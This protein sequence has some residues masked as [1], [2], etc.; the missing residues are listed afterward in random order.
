VTRTAAAAALAEPELRAL[1]QPT[2]EPAGGSTL[3]LQGVGDGAAPEPSSASRVFAI[4]P[5][6]LVRSG[7]A[8][9]ARRAFGCHAHG[10][11]DVNQAL[12]ALALVK[13]PPRL[14]LLG[15]R[16]GDDAEAIVAA[17]RELGAPIVCVLE[18]GDPSL[19]RSALAARADG[20]LLLDSA[21]T[22]TLLAT[23][24]AVEAGELVV[25]QALDQF[26]DGDD[27]AHRTV[28]ERCLE[29]LRWLADGLHDEEI[30]DRL[31]I[32]T[33]SVRKHIA[34]AQERLQARTRTQVVAMVARNGLL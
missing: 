4:D 19:S 1:A 31:E 23:V 13:S 12:A 7:L 25:P 14:L 18:S 33:S 15:L 34:T 9:L 3:T 16:P 17:A 32:S 5:R 8:G 21:G 2:R 10:L 24:A 29:V 28:T 27:G 11:L 22:E 26:R 20:Y 6:P 30:A